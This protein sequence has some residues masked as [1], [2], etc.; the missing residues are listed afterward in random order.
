MYVRLA[1][2]YA[3]DIIIYFLF[4]SSVSK[5]LLFICLFISSVGNILFLVKKCWKHLYA[6]KGQPV[7]NF[8]EVPTRRRLID[9]TL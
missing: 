3:S 4:I 2:F 1:V 5:W 9:L 8:F 6:L 7:V